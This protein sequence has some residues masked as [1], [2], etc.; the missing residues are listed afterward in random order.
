[1]PATTPLFRW[2]RQLP[3]AWLCIGMG[4]CITADSGAG[5]APHGVTEIAIERDCFGCDK[6]RSLRLRSDGAALV[7]EGGKARHGG[8]DTLRQGWVDA[9]EFDALARLLV[10]RGFFAMKDRYEDPELQDG[11]WTTFRATRG[12]HQKEVFVR[13]DAAPP[14]LRAVETAIDALG[15]RI[16]A[17]R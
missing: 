6:A 16:R 9:G 10:A 2:L 8:S 11:A 3:G 12:A 17:S 15:S 1:M 13:E 5:G 7:T 4:A 14:E